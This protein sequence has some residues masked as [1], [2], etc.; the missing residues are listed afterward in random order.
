M[1]AGSATTGRSVEKAL[2][3]LYAEES[4]KRFTPKDISAMAAN[5]YEPGRIDFPVTKR[6]MIN[7]ELES[8]EACGYIE[9]K[10]DRKEKAF[11][12]YGGKFTEKMENLCLRNGVR[13]KACLIEQER[14][15]ISPVRYSLP[16]KP[17]PAAGWYTKG[18]SRKK[19]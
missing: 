14:Q 11:T 2:I 15:T 19:S 6:D 5:G 12:L 10:K 8:L 3:H 13:T 18:I 16:T 7:R 4:R 9:L 17:F 1:T